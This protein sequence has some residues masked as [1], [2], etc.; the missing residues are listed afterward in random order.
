MREAGGPLVSNDLASWLLEGR[1]PTEAEM[2]GYLED[3]IRRS[4]LA[5]PMTREQLAEA[6]VEQMQNFL[7]S[8]SANR[9]LTDSTPISAGWLRECGIPVLDSIPDCATVPRSSIKLEM[10]GSSVT[11]DAATAQMKATFSEPFKWFEATVTINDG[12]DGSEV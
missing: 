7:K 4:L 12:H 1:K 10:T 6:C 3:A 11:R 9:V 2:R 5:A 8:I